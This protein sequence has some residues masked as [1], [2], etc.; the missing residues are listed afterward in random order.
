MAAYS[1]LQEEEFDAEADGYTATRH[2]RE[3]GTR[4]FDAVAQVISA[5]QSSTTALL[6]STETEQ[7]AYA[8]KMNPPT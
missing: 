5:G 6:G 1:K 3:V 8:G 7:F 4:Y 2:Q